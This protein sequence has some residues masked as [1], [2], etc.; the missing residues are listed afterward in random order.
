MTTSVTTK[1]RDVRYYD[2]T[3]P[4]QQAK[5]VRLLFEFVQ[6]GDFAEALKRAKV[7]AND[8]SV[9]AAFK[10]LKESILGAVPLG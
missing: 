3:I 5:L 7:P 10:E 9:L 1:P 4:E 6:P 8:Q 2:V